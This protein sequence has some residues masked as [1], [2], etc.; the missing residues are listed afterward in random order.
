MYDELEEYHDVIAR[1]TE[2]IK[3]GNAS[4]HVYNNRGVAHFE[5]CEIDDA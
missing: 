1:L 5:I 3:Q 2:Y 4:T